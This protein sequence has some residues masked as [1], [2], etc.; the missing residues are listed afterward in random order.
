M[1]KNLKKKYEKGGEGVRTKREKDEKME[2]IIDAQ[3]FHPCFCL[4]V[5]SGAVW[6]E[7]WKKRK[8]Q[9]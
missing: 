2:K 4:V 6:K 7:R 5:S 8:S 3:S 9:H 1:G